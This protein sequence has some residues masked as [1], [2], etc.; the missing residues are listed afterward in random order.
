VSD[1]RT[2]PAG[3]IFSL[4]LTM[5]AA[6]RLLMQASR[7]RALTRPIHPTK[8]EEWMNKL[9][10]L[11]LRRV[12]AATI[13]A[14]SL[15]GTGAVRAENHALIMT[16]DYAG[17]LPPGRGA[18]PG[19]EKDGEFAKAMAGRIGV[20]PKNIL[21]LK[22]RDLTIGGMND[23]LQDLLQNRMREGD[24]VF[25]YYSGHGTQYARETGGSK[26]VQAV[27]T[28]DLKFLADDRLRETLD[29]LAA[30][31]SQ[32][33]MFNDSCFSGGQIGSTKELSRSADDA[34]PKVY[35]PGKTGSAND[36]GYVCGEAEN[37]EADFGA[38]TLGVVAR[39]RSTQILY[40]A[41]AADSEVSRASSNGS[42]ATQ[43]WAYCVNGRAADR[44]GD[45]FV[46]GEELRQCSQ[47]YIDQ[48][49]GR[50][51]TITL[52]GNPQ[53]LVGFAG[54]GNDTAPVT[55][56]AGTLE[57]LYRSRDTGI[58]VGLSVSRNRLKIGRDLLD[59]TVTTDRDGYL[60]LLH[61]ASDGKFYVLFP[62]NLDR[63][64]FVKAG[65]YR[66]PREKWAIQAQGPAGSGYIMAYLST[67]PKDFTKGFET[68]GTFATGDADEGT[69]RKLGVIALDG[70]YGASPVV[71]V[72][73]VK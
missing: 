61:V 3:K 19:I 63:N 6:M 46:N 60:Q 55:N 16:I 25:L 15:T 58:S 44:N 54:V 38:R 36:A 34:V 24:K 21:W 28:H 73:E 47:T 40:V 53:L 49:F 45:G 72:E 32:V 71:T 2:E 22:N 39:K 8:A 1:A 20:P 43:A 12:L 59:F 14:C 67:G 13:A 56:L 35:Q 27:V 33:V 48:H 37:K 18:L 30:K 68:E 52:V 64:N 62:N 10:N 29:A 11:N 50:R 42:W 17:V 57:S 51:Q 70:R 23:A 4:H 7:E 69:T 26:C 9:P 31:A 41:A 5:G 65:S 66:F